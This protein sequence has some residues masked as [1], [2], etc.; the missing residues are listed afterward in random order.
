MKINTM[1]D[2]NVCIMNSMLPT[3]V[4]EDINKR[5]SDWLSSGGSI[6]D[7]Y[8]KQQFKYAERIIEIN[9]K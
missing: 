8:I 6:T 1:D 7:N 9:K 4:V 2:L 3:I 5:I